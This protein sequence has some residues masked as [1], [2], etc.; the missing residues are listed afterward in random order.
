MHKLYDMCLHILCGYF[1]N[2][3]AQH[4]IMM[5][6]RWML[7]AKRWTQNPPSEARIKLVFGVIAVSLILFGIEWYFGWPDW[8]TVNPSPGRLR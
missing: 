3:F 6:L 7:R 8:L 1:V 2:L 5:N 4:H